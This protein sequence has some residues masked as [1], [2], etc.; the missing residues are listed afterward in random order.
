[1]TMPGSE[2]EPMEWALQSFDLLYYLD[3]NEIWGQ[4]IVVLPVYMDSLSLRCGLN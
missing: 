2:R 3:C 4:Y 1:M